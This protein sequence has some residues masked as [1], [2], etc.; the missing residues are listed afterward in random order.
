MKSSEIIKLLEQR[1][2]ED[3]FYTEVSIDYGQRR[4]D[5]WAMKKSWSKPL[6]T[7][8]EVKVSRSDFINDHK[9]QDYLPYCNEIYLVCPVGIADISEVPEGFGLLVVASTGNRLM[10][11]KKA[12]YR[13]VEIKEQFYRG[14]LMA[15]ADSRYGVMSAGELELARRTG[16]YT[17]YKNYVA[18]RKE[19]KDLGYEVLRKVGDVFKENEKLKIENKALEEAK[20]MYNKL[21]KIF[22]LEYMSDGYLSKDWVLIR[23]RERMKDFEFPEEQ[24][25]NSLSRIIG[26]LMEAKTEIQNFKK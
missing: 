18:G 1:H 8:Y 15:K 4:M 26:K 23:M 2:S 22:D 10:M 16:T 25:I 5:A 24:M 20:D 13:Q 3:V 9:M 19:L 14:L 6:V 17:E 12:P 21:L 11:K 7:A